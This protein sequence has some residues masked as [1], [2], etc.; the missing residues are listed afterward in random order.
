MVVCELTVNRMGPDPMPLLMLRI[1]L[2]LSVI[3][4][5]MLS[6]STIRSVEA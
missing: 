5:T 3:C 2:H 6:Y 1:K 4:I